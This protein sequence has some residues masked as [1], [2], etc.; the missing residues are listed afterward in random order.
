MH[1]KTL[2]ASQLMAGSMQ[3]MA[4]QQILVTSRVLGRLS[5]AGHDIQMVAQ[6]SSIHNTGFFVCYYG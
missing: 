1:G 2:P 3:P 6:C 4:V 5:F